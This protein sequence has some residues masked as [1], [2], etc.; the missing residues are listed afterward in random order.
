MGIFDAAFIPDGPVTLENVA[1]WMGGG[2]TRSGISVGPDSALRQATV[3][4]CVR[5]VSED[6]AK[7]P[8]IL[9][10]RM[11]NGGRERATDHP[12][13][14]VLHRRPN[15]WQTSFQFREM[16][17]AHIELRGFAA[18]HITR[19]PVRKDRSGEV[20]ELIPIHPGR[21]SV[22]MTAEWDVEFKVNGKPVDRRDIL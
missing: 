7:V 20:R 17:Q 5:V 11:A 16:C 14:R 15:R 4:A 12:L 1:R 13:Y 8:L 19:Y 6:I 21:V 10:R 22:R 18:A 3:Y 2:P 9:Y